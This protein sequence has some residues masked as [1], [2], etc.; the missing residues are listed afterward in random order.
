MADTV[1]VEE[2]MAEAVAV[3]TMADKVE[4]VVGK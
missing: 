1:G 3:A 4:A 2:A